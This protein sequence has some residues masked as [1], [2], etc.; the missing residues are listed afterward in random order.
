MGLADYRKWKFKQ[1]VLSFLREEYGITEDDLRKIHYTKPEPEPTPVVETKEDDKNIMTPQDI[2]KAF[3]GDIEE[4]Y[5][6][7]RHN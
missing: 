2:V 5:P 7:G 6:Y 4:F 1:K 3:S